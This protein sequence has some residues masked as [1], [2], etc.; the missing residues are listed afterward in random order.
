MKHS[1]I[2]FFLFLHRFFPI[3]G[4]ST[5]IT[6]IIKSQ[7]GEHIPNAS[8]LVKDA[9]SNSII[10]YT[11][12]D[13]EGRY[14]IG[15]KDAVDELLI[16]VS[17]M[18]IASQTK[19]IKNESQVID[20][21]VEEKDIQLR[22]VTIKAPK[23]SYRKDT[24]NYSV[25][26]FATDKDIVIGD[27]LNR[28]PGIEVMESGQIKYQGRA[29]NK[30]YIEN[31]DM[32]NGRYGIATRNI[33]A[34]DVATVQVMEN[35]QPIKA[36]DS[37]R[38]SNEA[39]INLKLKEEAKGTLSVMTQ[40]G[41]GLSPLLWEDELT[42]MYFAR[43]NQHITTYKT[44][45]TG[46]DITG[47]L[48][49]FTSSQN[50][51]PEQYTGIQM[52]SLPDIAKKRYLFNNTHATTF[53]NLIKTGEENELNF[54][55]IY[56]N[57]YEKRE[58]SEQSLYFINGDSILRIDENVGSAGNI[59]HLETEI[60]YNEN[61]TSRYLNNYL[62]IDGSWENDRGNIYQSR[63]INQRLYR[64]SL[65]VR[66]HFYWIKKNQSGNGGFEVMSQ[67]GFRTSPQDLTIRP[68]LYEDLMNGGN[69]YSILRQDIRAHAF[70]S[71]NQFVFLT[72]FRMGNVSVNP[73][74]GFNVEINSL[75]S[76]LYA[77]GTSGNAVSNVPDSMRND[78]TK[79][80]YNPY[81]GM[82][83]L[84]KAGKFKL[85]LFV[86]AGYSYYRLD[87]KVLPGRNENLQRF[88]I[89]PSLSLQYE[90]SRKL[91]LSTGAGTYS[92]YNSIYELYSGSILQSYRYLNSYDSRLARY[93]GSNASLQ[94]AY[95]DII[96]LLFAGGGVSYSYYKTEMIYSQSFDGILSMTT[97][98][99]MPNHRN[100]I[101]TNGR[102]SKGFDLMKITAGLDAS[103]M[104]SSSQQIRQGSLVDYN[105]GFF[106]LTGKLSAIPVS[107]LI[108]S[109]QAT[110]GKSEASVEEGETFAPIYS[111][112]HTATADFTL[113]GKLRMG[114]RFEHYYNSAV[115]ET[116]IYFA[117]LSMNYAWKQFNFSL[118]WN[119]IFNTKYYTQAYYGDM[120][121]FHYQYHIRPSNIILKVKMKLK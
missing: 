56:Y 68:G 8:V 17:G 103:Y 39:A 61:K 26:A 85:N 24:I 67:T 77:G 121:E 79:S 18:T 106:T 9:A 4:Q 52:P 94:L 118:N 45:N 41:L 47:E 53:N 63:D 72:P 3:Y 14:K 111:L 74:A 13:N 100:T 109:Y 87:N 36:I 75:C 7:K 28:M 25:A 62:N 114:T 15:F 95:K 84:Y 42:G 101:G 46:Y 29:I 81:L 59:D 116:D 12:S 108:L 51:Q 5:S 23:I 1:L 83:F 65:G 78:L 20:F 120:N 76:E 57:D 49:S 88:Y 86:P 90:F 92:G 119:N 35:H 70:V 31:M 80:R 96:N 89:D 54:N 60:R 66:N 30:F 44:N 73:K 33:T 102:I 58:S 6:G 34:K 98:Q 32:L 64:P 115:Q 104:T 50:L 110:G 11:Y 107:F 55:L 27:V 71:N 43:K 113:F 21:I 10:T 2:L 91:N 37:L 48:R 112:T 97:M 99:N 22:E 93:R 16:T 38:I 69:A 82:D 105:T 19:K 40:L 117:D